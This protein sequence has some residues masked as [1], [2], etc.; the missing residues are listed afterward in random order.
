DIMALKF[1]TT[2][3]LEI[4]PAAMP[5]DV[6]ILDLAVLLDHLADRSLEIVEHF[7][8]DILADRSVN[9]LE[10]VI[11]V[12]LDGDEELFVVLRL[13]PM[14]LDGLE[15]CCRQRVDNLSTHRTIRQK[16]RPRWS[17]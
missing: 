14:G 11:S 5:L 17:L 15:N 16:P 2:Q 6:H 3:R 13:E 8:H 12:L 4:A 10:P 7:V 1:S 9:T